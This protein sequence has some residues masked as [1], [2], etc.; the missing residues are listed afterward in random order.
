MW[1]VCS[2][3]VGR[4]ACEKISFQMGGVKFVC[5]E[6]KRDGLRDGQRGRGKTGEEMVEKMDKSNRGGIW[7]GERIGSLPARG[8]QGAKVGRAGTEN[9][10][11]E[12]EGCLCD[13]DLSIAEKGIR[14]Q[15]REIGG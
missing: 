2:G 3:E 4:D 6:I 15:V 1:E 11:G 8:K 10:G 9:V 7:F 14:E 12:G 5:E 13:S